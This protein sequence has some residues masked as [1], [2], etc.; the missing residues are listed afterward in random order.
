MFTSLLGL[1]ALACDAGEQ[2]VEAIDAPPVQ[3]LEVRVSAVDES[4][5]VSRVAIAADGSTKVTTATSF[6]VRLDRF[7]LPTSATRQALCLASTTTPIRSLEQ[8]LSGVFLEPIYDP[9]L[10]RVT[11]RQRA[12]DRL[13]PDTLYQLA[14]YSPTEEAPF[15]FVAFDGAP[16][17]APLQLQFRT[18]AE[19]PPGT[20]DEAPL[21]GDLFCCGDAANPC[22]LEGF[23]AATT[24]AGC[25][26]S[27]CH[28]AS[29]DGSLGPSM[30]LNLSPPPANAAQLFEDPILATAVNHVAH[31]TQTGEVADA[32][33]QPSA[34]SRFG[35]AMALIRPFEPGNSYLLY[36]LAAEPANYPAG[37]APSPEELARLRAA[38]VVGMPMPAYGGTAL[39]GNS[40]ELL[41]AWIAA[42]A[43]TRPCTP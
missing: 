36:K 33:V 16:F 25:A 41:S 13:A 20:T 18:V 5:A 8:C 22:P 38:L 10:R 35:R 26:F 43:P 2:E 34:T 42:G 1:F 6:E 4:G 9:A 3:L 11:Y 23:G 37:D 17:A 30:G 15:G 39:T 40:L 14:F 7:L 27:P 29:S 21:G 12:G 28:A 32:P 31:Q 19:D 24:F